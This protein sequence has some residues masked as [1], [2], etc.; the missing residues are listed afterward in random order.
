MHLSYL[1][2]DKYLSWMNYFIPSSITVVNYQ[3]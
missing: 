1:D 2:F 3:F